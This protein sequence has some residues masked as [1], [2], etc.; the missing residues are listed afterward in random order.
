MTVHDA[1]APRALQPPPLLPVG[2]QQFHRD[3]FLNYQLNRLYSLGY[4]PHRALAAIGQRV[5]SFDDWCLEFARL[6]E[7]AT[8][9]GQL[10]QAAFAYRAAE[11]LTPPGHYQKVRYYERFIETF[12][13][14]FVNHGIERHNVPYAGGAL[15][16]IRL[17][18]RGEHPRGTVLVHGGFDS[19]LE[20]FVGIYEHLAAAGYE[21][22]AFDGPGQG[23]ALRRHGL[24]FDHDWEKPTASVLDHF[25]RRDVTLLGIYMGGYWCLRAAAFE[26]RVTRVIVM[27]SVLDWLEQ[28]RPTTRRLVRAMVRRRRFMNAT[29][30]LRMRLV[31]LLDHA[32]RQCLMQIGGDKPMDAVDWLLEMNAAHQQ[33]HRVTQDVLLLHGERDRFQPL[34]LHHAQRRSLISARSV[35]ERIFTEEEHAA[36]HCQMGNLGLAVDTVLGWLHGHRDGPSVASHRESD[37]PCERPETTAEPRPP[38][39]P[40]QGR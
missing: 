16:T 31:P 3:R 18:A 35:T 24:M 30:R 4:M 22:L 13:R 2:Y 20:E 33:P 17:A 28:L 29:I 26:T 11:F 5:R 9:Q 1:E 21:V 32:I 8:A 19:L 23:G 7:R 12:D 34:A 6:A 10:H 25:D 40:R 37:A 38:A 36:Y 27:A 14:A 39:G 15:P